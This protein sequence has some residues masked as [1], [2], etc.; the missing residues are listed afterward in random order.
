MAYA[1]VYGS[2]CALIGNMPVYGF[3]PNGV[4]FSEGTYNNTC[5][6]G[7]AGDEYLSIGGCDPTNTTTRYAMITNNNRVYA[8]N[9]SVVV[10]CGKSMSFAEWQATGLDPGSTVSDMPS[11]STIIAWAAQLLNIPN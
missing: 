8:P 9:A 3:D 10:N 4:V 2:R 5:I 7:A 6:L 1:N 11:A